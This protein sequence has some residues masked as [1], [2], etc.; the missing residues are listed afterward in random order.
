MKPLST[1]NFGGHK[2]FL[3]QLLKT[4]MA[5][6]HTSDKIRRRNGE[7]KRERKKENEKRRG[8]DGR[9]AERGGGMY[10]RSR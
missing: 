1:L 8:R 9:R 2:L 3:K 4:L 6:G 7:R 5:M 10:F